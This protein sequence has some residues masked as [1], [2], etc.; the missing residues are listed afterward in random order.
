MLDGSHAVSHNRRYFCVQSAALNLFY[1]L[2]LHIN[3]PNYWLPTN[4]GQ[5]FLIT[6]EAVHISHHYSF[7]DWSRLIIFKLRKKHLL[8]LIGK[9]SMN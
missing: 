9:V 4:Y 6:L 2:D 8:T 1:V 3:I 5:P 7:V